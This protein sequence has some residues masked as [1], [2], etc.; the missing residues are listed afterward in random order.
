MS[1]TLIC[2]DDFLAADIVA[3]RYMGLNPHKIKYLSYFM[4][5]WNIDIDNDIA[6]TLNG[7]I[8]RDYFSSVSAYEDFKVIDAWKDIKIH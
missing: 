3:V 4:D 6:V 7:N 5:E 1:K 2:S 8:K